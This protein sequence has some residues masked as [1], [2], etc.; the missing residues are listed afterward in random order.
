[1][2]KYFHDIRMYARRHTSCSCCKK[3]DR[4][5]KSCKEDNSSIIGNAS[6]ATKCKLFE[7]DGKFY[8]KGRRAALC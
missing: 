4:T 2:L 5:H 7:F 8:E 6:I 3:Y 1:M